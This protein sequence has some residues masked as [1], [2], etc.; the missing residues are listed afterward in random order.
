MEENNPPLHETQPSTP[1]P[2]VYDTP[3]PLVPG[4]PGGRNLPKWLAI[5]VLVLICGYIIYFL[6]TYILGLFMLRLGS[7]P[8]SQIDWQLSATPIIRATPEPDMAEWKTMTKKTVSFHY[9]EDFSET[10]L[11]E[12]YYLLPTRLVV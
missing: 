5:T 11:G 6:I 3:K 7:L 2:P 8:P 9:P 12:P 4:Q 1:T 10:N